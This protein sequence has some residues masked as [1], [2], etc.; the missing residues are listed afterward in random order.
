MNR[1]SPARRLVRMAARSPGRST[2]GPAVV[3]VNAF[4]SLERTCARVVLPSRAGRKGHGQRG[5]PRF[6]AAA[7]RMARFSLTWSWPITSLRVF[8]R[9][10]W[11]RRSSGRASG[12]TRRGE[13]SSMQLIIPQAVFQRSSGC[14]IR[15]C[16]IILLKSLSGEPPCLTCMYP[17]IPW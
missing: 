17:L 8:G 15:F 7:I 6:W 14:T 12:E 2:A 11:C 13:L 3:D 1:I 10:A 4:I 9:S 16:R 5:S